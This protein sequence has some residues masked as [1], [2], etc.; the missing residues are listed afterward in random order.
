MCRGEKKIN[1]ESHTQLTEPFKNESET[2]TFSGEENL[3]EFDASRPT[4]KEQLTT[5]HTTGTRNRSPRR[6]AAPRN[7]SQAAMPL[8]PDSRCG[9]QLSREPVLGARASSCC[10][11]CCCEHENWSKDSWNFLNEEG[12]Q[13]EQIHGVS[14]IDFPSLTDF[15]KLCL[16]IEGKLI[17]LSN[18]VGNEC[19]EIF[20]TPPCSKWGWVK[21]HKGRLDF[22]T[23]A[24]LVPS[25]YILK[26]PYKEM[27]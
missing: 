18:M 21:R 17:T 20:E 6:P 9:F 2:K 10:P 24:S 25:S 14:A 27:H 8:W 4:L 13:K 16:M 7:Q 15:S 11:G 23:L 12:P 3:R 19:K 1:P 22:F 5:A 26:M